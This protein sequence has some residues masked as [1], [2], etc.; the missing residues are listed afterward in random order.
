MN[1][2]VSLRKR[3]EK[4]SYQ[5]LID[6]KYHSS[7][8]GFKDRKEAKRAGDSAALKIKTPER[9]KSTFKEIADLYINDG[10]KEESTK[11]SYRQWLKNLE[12]IWNIEITK[13]KYQD[14]SPLVFDYYSTHKYNGTKSL[15]GLGKSVF[16][17]A[18]RKMK[19]DVDNPF[20]EVVIRKQS[21]K[22]KREP[23]V[24]TFDEIL[25]LINDEPDPYMR[26]LFVCAG[27]AGMRIAEARAIRP[28]V[29]DLKTQRVKVN[30][31]RT[32]SNKV[33]VIMKSEGGERS[34]KMHDRMVEEYLKLPIP[35]NKEDFLLQ[36]FISS[37][38][39]KKAFERHGY[40]DTTLHS[41]RHSFATVCIQRGMDFKTLAD[42]IGD[43]LETVISTYAHVNMDM[44]KMADDILSGKD[45]TKY[46]TTEAANKESQQKTI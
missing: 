14:V 39:V 33:K 37:T 36:K 16:K 11:R 19:I 40:H 31:Q 7:K 20:E 10:M 44:Q 28:A 17:F 42:T 18:Q 38:D 43:K 15:V 45:L 21:D 32:A 24:F 13:I 2:T 6:G 3:G 4:W 26:W 46:E 9:S 23:R 29:I 8:S 41:L 27:L 5:I 1:Y 25:K 30:K 12:P 22:T 35:I 34:L